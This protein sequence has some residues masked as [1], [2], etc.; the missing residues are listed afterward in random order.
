METKIDLERP[1]RSPVWIPVIFLIVVSWIVRASDL[2]RILQQKFWSP[3]S[4][5]NLAHETWVQ[6]LYRYGTWPALI[7]AGCGLVVCLASFLVSR[8]KPMRW[9]GGFLAVAMILG[10]GLLVNSALKGHFGRPRPKQVIEFGGS[11][12]FLPLGEPAFDQEGRS[13]PSGHAS[14]GFF[15]FAPCIYLWQRHRRAALG[16]GALALAHGGLMSFGRMAQGAHWLSDNLWAA[17]I[18]YLSSWML[19]RWIVCPYS[20]TTADPCSVV[21]PLACDPIRE[22]Y[23]TANR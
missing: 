3:F 12:T 5:W 19:H 21:L 11:R 9:F 7:V 10:P 22:S 14:T 20:R 17:G 6:L 13:F 8:V 18:V 1:D 2:D 4:G 16:F 15:W 23:A